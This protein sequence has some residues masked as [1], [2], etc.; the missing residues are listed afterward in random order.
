MAAELQRYSLQQTKGR[1]KKVFVI[2]YDKKAV[3][4]VTSK[5]RVLSAVQ[6][7]Y[8]ARKAG[9]NVVVSRRTEVQLLQS[10]IK[11][12]TCKTPR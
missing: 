12:Q 2:K 4:S 6:E 10:S 9:E 1:G 3:K 8:L 11:A 5:D 7:H